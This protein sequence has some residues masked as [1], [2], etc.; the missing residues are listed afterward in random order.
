VFKQLREKA[1]ECIMKEIEASCNNKAVNNVKKK[2]ESLE[3]QLHSY[4]K[5]LMVLSFN[6]AVYDIP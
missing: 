2:F 4:L 3:R 1:D 5:D 6:G